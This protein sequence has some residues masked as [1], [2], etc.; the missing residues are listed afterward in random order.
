MKKKII[1]AAVA[2]AVGFPM[3][4][5]AD[6]TVYG[7]I[8][9]GSVHHDATYNGPLCDEDDNCPVAA[10]LGEAAK[11]CLANGDDEGHRRFR[12]AYLRHLEA[13]RENRHV[14]AKGSAAYEPP[15]HHVGGFAKVREGS[16]GVS[17]VKGHSHPIKREDEKRETHTPHDSRIVE[18]TERREKR[19][20]G[21]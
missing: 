14:F 20:L 6:A 13:A 10:A 5:M 18:S 9:V 1:V 17:P 4:A 21:S 19:F 11:D 2:A 16:K 3:A 12:S 15:T 8:R 7:K